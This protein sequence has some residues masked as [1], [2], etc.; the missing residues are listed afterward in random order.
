MLTTLLTFFVDPESL[1]FAFGS[2]AA[3]IV[4]GIEWPIFYKLI[5]KA[6]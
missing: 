4:N 5:Y 6:P 2:Y 3:T 1:T